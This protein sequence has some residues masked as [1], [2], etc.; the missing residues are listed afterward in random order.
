MRKIFIIALCAIGIMACNQN[1]SKESEMLAMQR[2]SLNSIIAQRESE[3]DEIM[4]IVNEIEEGFERIDEA[5]ERVGVEKFGEGVNQRARI[6][7]DMR[8]I[9]EKMEHNRRLIAKLQQQM[10]KSSLTSAQLTRTIK[11][12]TTQMEEKAQQLA[13]LQAELN[14]KNLRITELDEKV[15]D[16]N[17]DVTELK[18]DTVQKSMTISEQDRQLH[19]AWFVFGT[20]SELKEQRILVDGDVLK[21]DFNRDYFTKIDIRMDREIKLYSRSAKMMTSHP[22]NSYTLQRD[23]NKHY[24]LNITDPELFW[25]TSKYLVILVK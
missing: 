21:E 23:M 9:Q 3:I 6:Q 19:T 12:L 10:K 5:E 14:E 11:N 22:S 13:E 16:L 15:T 17:K 4:T 2:D 18:E 1:K 24:V 25:S 20:K 8:F 7:E